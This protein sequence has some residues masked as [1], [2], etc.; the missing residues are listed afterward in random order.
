MKYYILFIFCSISIQ[1]Q[2][3]E[4][5]IGKHRI[6]LELDIDYNDDR[7]T[8]FYFYKSQLQNIQLEG[9]FS[10][11]EL[12]LFEKFSDIK[13]QKELFTLII[14]KD[15][16][17]GTWKN[18]GKTLQVDLN[19]TTKKIDDY[20]LMNLEY[21]RDS[22]TIHNTKEL[23][24]FTEKYSK[25]SLFRLGNGFT[26]SEREFM[27]P[28]LDTIH[29]NYATIG[30][31][32]GWADINIEMELISNQYISFT[33]YSSIY[34]GGAHP[35]HNMVGYNFDFK[36]KKQLDRITDLYPNLDHFQLLKRK[37][38]NDTD[39]D[40]EC[41]YFTD[42]EWI[43]E[44]YS[45]VLTKNGITITPS[46]PHAMTPCEIGFPLT[47]KELLETDSSKKVI[48]ATIDSV[49]ISEIKQYSE[50]FPTIFDYYKYEKI[51]KVDVWSDKMFGRCCSNT[52]L[53]FNENLF[54][55]IDSNFNDNRYPISNLSDTRYSTAYVFKPGAKVKINLQLDLSSDKSFLSGKYS[56]K[57]LLKPNDLIMK[58]IKLSV[59]NGYVKSKALFYQNARVKEMKVYVNNIYKE[60]VILLDTPLVQQFEVD[61]VFKT[62]DTIT[63]EPITFYKGS[64]YDDI[65]ISEIQTNLG[66]IAVS[67]LNKKHNLMELINKN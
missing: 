43:W 2:T 67:E 47:Y 56:N 35:N 65:C 32:C 18:K 51:D 66:R 8:A 40:D 60:T 34:C 41:G 29:A 20:K 21:A 17:A 19:K 4:G 28:K 14:N 30:L 33:E 55:K 48:Q 13:E 42:G 59:I 11:N 3:Y 63:L 44:Y 39:F 52:D 12:V 53:T 25:K 16:I 37:Y 6:F 10:N 5:T 7:A 62:N 27:N 9:S 36:N 49:S 50:E 1:A 46:Y 54:F 22:I 24:W 31:D 45:W 23:V 38:E 57:N 61:A 26:S 15:T 58:P 64:K